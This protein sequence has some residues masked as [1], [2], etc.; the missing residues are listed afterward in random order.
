MLTFAHA[1]FYLHLDG[2]PGW[3]RDRGL[4]AAGGNREGGWYLGIAGW[5]VPV[6]IKLVQVVEYVGI[7]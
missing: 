3:S 5:V 2:L 4:K 1:W 7:S 6:L